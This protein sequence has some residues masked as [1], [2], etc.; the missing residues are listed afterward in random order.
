MN[1]VSVRAFEQLPI[2]LALGLRLSIF[3]SL[4]VTAC[5]TKPSDDTNNQLAGMYRLLII[6]NKDSTGAWKQQEWARDGDGYIVYDGKGHMAVQ[7]LP[8]GYKD[9]QWMDEESSINSDKLS[10]KTD[11]MS[12][13]ELRAAVKEFA[14]SYVY[15]GNYSVSDTADV[16]THDRL[17][18]SIP[19]IWGTTVKRRL[20]FKGDTIVLEPLNANRRLKWIRVK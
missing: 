19:A 9:F 14:S 17:I 18:S 4:F 12:A 1:P 15:F 13:D 10:A 3:V 8:K 6:E 7:I 16:V 2:C 5:K 20:L 11:S